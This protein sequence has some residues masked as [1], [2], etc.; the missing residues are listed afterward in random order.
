MAWEVYISERHNVYN[1]A[2]ICTMW[3]GPFF[4]T[5]Q[6]SKNENIQQ[7]KTVK[8]KIFLLIFPLDWQSVIER[9][10]FADAVL[11]CT[12]DK[13]HKVNTCK[14]ILNFM[15]KN[16]CSLYLIIFMNGLCCSTGPCSCLCKEGLPHSVGETNGSECFCKWRVKRKKF[17]HT[18]TLSLCIHLNR[19][20]L[21]KTAEPL[22]MF[23][24]GVVWCYQWVTFCVMTQLSPKSRYSSFLLMQ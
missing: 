1:I 15:C 18:F 2:L 7:I 20:P 10:K 6:H 23:A 8:K 11:I 22:W 9:E 5:S 21:L 14:C 24:F 12:P 4:F 17:S 3:Y 19:R 16:L 13:L